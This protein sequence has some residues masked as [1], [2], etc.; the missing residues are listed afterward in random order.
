M[1]VSG[2]KKVRMNTPNRSK[3][4]SSQ[5]EKKNPRAGGGTDRPLTEN[6]GRVPGTRPGNHA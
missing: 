3:I 1:L 4:N 2:G 6:A 5:Q